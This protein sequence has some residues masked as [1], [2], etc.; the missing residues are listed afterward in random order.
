VK[1]KEVFVAVKR[2]PAFVEYPN[3]MDVLPLIAPKQAVSL[4]QAIG[5][6]KELAGAGPAS[7]V[8]V[9]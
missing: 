4:T 2:S 6:I 9:P 1:F 3:V 8:G 5:T 7:L